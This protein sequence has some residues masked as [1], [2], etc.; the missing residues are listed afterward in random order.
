[1][2]I[3][4][5][6]A[7]ISCG[8]IIIDRD[9]RQRKVIETDDL[10]PSIKARG[11]LNPIIVDRALHLIAGERRLTASL[12]LGLPNHSHPLRG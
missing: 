5:D 6:Y 8:S 12:R 3:S 1:V 9:D 7:R 2:S 10:E 4:D 11:V